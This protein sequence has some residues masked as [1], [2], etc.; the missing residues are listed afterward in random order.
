MYGEGC[1][2]N[3]ENGGL[4]PPD[5]MVD[6]FDAATIEECGCT[7]QVSGNEGCYK[8]RDFSALPGFESD[9]RQV[10]I[11]LNETCSGDDEGGDAT[12]GDDEGGD[13]TSSS[14]ADKIGFGSAIFVLVATFAVVFV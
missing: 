4:I 10:F 6:D 11:Y 3:G 12:G 7:F 1:Y 13:D 5:V 2:N 9:P 8:I 14:L